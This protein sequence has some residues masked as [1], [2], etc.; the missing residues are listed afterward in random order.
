MVMTPESAHLSFSDIAVDD[1][2]NPSM[3]R[4]TIKQSKTDPF[5]QGINSKTASAPCPVKAMLNY[6]KV[7]GSDP[8]PLFRFKN[9]QFLT[10]DRLVQHLRDVLKRLGID[11]K[12]YCSH[13]FQIEAA[14]TAASRG[15]EDSVIKTL[16]RW[17]SQAYQEYV[18]IPREQPASYSSLL[19]SIRT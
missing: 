8:G 13:S 10:R 18:R 4:I 7:R 14:T 16:G 5:R 2:N 9:G 6:L 3:L 12:K 15:V 17:K 19:S 1:A 11:P